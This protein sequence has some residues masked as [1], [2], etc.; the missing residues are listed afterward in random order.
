MS[1][2]SMHAWRLPVEQTNDTKCVL[3]IHARME[4]TTAG[5]LVQRRR[6]SNPCTHGDYEGQEE[7]IVDLMFQS[8]HAW[9][10]RSF[11]SSYLHCYLPIH[12]RMETTLTLTD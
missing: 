10:L 4:T 1:F 9:R 8:M 11:C 2:Q 5:R 12:A 7:V 3:P 6:T